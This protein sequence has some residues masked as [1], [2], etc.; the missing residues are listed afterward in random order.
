MQ[1]LQKAG[2]ACV[3]AEAQTSNA[4]EAVAPKVP[5]SDTE[6]QKPGEATSTPAD[7]EV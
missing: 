4:E 5:T 1:E 7:T 2:A 3:V 6:A